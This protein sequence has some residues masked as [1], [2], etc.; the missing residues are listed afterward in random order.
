MFGIAAQPNNLKKFYDK[1][2]ALDINEESATFLL[3]K[4]VSKAMTMTTAQVVKEVGE[5]KVNALGTPNEEDQAQMEK[6]QVSLE[7]L[8]QSETGKD[9]SKL[10]DQYVAELVADFEAQAKE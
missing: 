5:E 1:L 10:F 2:L 4:L 9:L 8:Y 7:A 6:W 3:G